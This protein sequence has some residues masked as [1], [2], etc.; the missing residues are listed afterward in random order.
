MNNWAYSKN[1]TMKL[2]SHQRACI[3]SKEMHEQLQEIITARP[4]EMSERA[5]YDALILGY[6]H[7]KRAERA[8]R[9]H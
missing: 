3:I 1:D 4:Y 7:G 2:I 6:I 8:K 5:A 9:K